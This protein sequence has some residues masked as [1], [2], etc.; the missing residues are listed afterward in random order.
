[1]KKSYLQFHPALLLLSC[2]NLAFFSCTEKVSEENGN[3]QLNGTWR[4]II[5]M[6]GQELPFNFMLKGAR[7]NLQ[8]E[9]YNAGE[10]L[11]VEDLSWKGDTLIIPM[12][13]F[14]TEIQAVVKSGSMNGYWIKNYAEDYALPFSATKAS[15]RF[16]TPEVSPQANI[17]GKWTV[18][19]Y[20][21]DNTDTTA[22]VGIFEQEGSKI[23][24]TFLTPTGDYRYLEGSMY[25]NQQFLLS[26]FDGEHAFLFE[27]N[28][29]DNGEIT[30]TFRSGKS[31][32]ERWTAQ[33]DEHASLPDANTL[34]F[35][36]EGYDKL[37]FEFPDL[38]GNMVSLSDA[39]FRD[40]VVIVQLFGSWC[41][42]C[43]DETRFLADWYRKNK[44]KEVA[45]VGLA[46]EK[47]DDFEYARNRVQKMAERLNVEYDF[48]IAGTA[49]KKAAAETLPMLNHVMS[50]PTTIFIDKEG[51]VRKIHTGF[52]G[53]GTG[54]Y[55]HRFIEEFNLFTDKLLAE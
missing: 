8:M 17:S 13:I 51:Q 16:P 50:F 11:E 45:I 48:L 22:A 44:N 9:I 38:E 23:T 31:W 47:K 34:T 54:E 39:R 18:R 46:Y 19:L 27:G 6:Q 28:L 30:G 7:E 32:Q 4:G 35:I 1:M 12:H 5:S 24:G 15:Y 14:D 25:N 2:L 40:K 49:D 36:K 53:P 10:V 43:M 55:Y 3:E 29:Q 21:E 26:A 41:P 42:N 33:K 37:A 52:S 20:G